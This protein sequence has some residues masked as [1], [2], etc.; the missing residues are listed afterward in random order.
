MEAEDELELE[1]E[2]EEGGGSMEVSVQPPAA[3]ATAAA[4]A[5]PPF[6]PS[7][8]PFPRSVVVIIHSA[9]PHLQG[10]R[11]HALDT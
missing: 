3:A 11:K 9:R 8:T 5:A 10:R 1:E 7:S 2:V 4:A 6:S